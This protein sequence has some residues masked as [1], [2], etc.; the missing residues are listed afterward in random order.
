MSTYEQEEQI[1]INV[2]IN[3][4]FYE[5]KCAL[6]H[7]NNKYKNMNF[8]YD[9]Y[10]ATNSDNFIIV[11]IFEGKKEA[12]LRWF[13]NEGFIKGPNTLIDDE[14]QIDN[15]RILKNQLLALIK[16]IQENY[17]WITEIHFNDS[18][19][20]ECC[21]LEQE[22]SLHWQYYYYYNLAL[23]GETW[24]EKY[25]NATYYVDYEN[26]KQGLFMSK[27]INDWND[28]KTYCIFT[29]DYMKSYYESSCTMRSFFQ[30][31]RADHSPLEVCKLIGSWISTYIYRLYNGTNSI[32]LSH[33]IIHIGMSK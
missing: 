2:S 19:Y 30:K 3:K 6:I 1:Q 7:I 31:L 32:N 18:G 14:K 13:D 5:I 9:E 4:D 15:H 27:P 23:F 17:K 21:M 25:F 20:F 22:N 26:I 24:F 10:N 8:R 29:E 28:F 33:G 12:Q 16:Y 11:Q